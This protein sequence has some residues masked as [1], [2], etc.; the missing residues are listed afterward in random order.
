MN[1]TFLPRLASAVSL[2]AVTAS[3][4]PATV[5]IGHRET[6]MVPISGAQYIAV[7]PA[8]VAPATVAIVGAQSLAVTLPTTGAADTA[9]A[10]PADATVS[11]RLSAGQTV[12]TSDI[13]FAFDSDQLMP[14][15]RRALDAIGQA[16]TDDPTLHVRVRGHTDGKG[17]ASYNMDLSVLR[18]KAVR[19]ALTDWYG[20]A[21]DRIAV[22]GVGMAE[23]VAT[24]ATA[25]GQGMNR[26]VEFVP[27]HVG[28]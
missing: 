20:I 22:E 6:S 28:K 19:Q 4:E 26:R 9:L 8:P 23:P 2:L 16:L 3:A 12:T 18:A 5:T 27:V 24:N 25:E 11:E 10:N 17:T 14:E 1:R 15:A 13:Y 7:A 21:A